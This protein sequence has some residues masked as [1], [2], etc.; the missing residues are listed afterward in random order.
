MEELS[1]DLLFFHGFSVKNIF[2]FLAPAL[3]FGYFFECIFV[4]KSLIFSTK[5]HRRVSL[6]GVLS[7]YSF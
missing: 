2:S 5:K 3:S 4:L 7:K 1:F 6:S